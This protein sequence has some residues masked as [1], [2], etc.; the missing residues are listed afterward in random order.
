M[1]SRVLVAAIMIFALSSTAPILAQQSSTPEEDNLL[2]VTKCVWP[3][4]WS[5]IYILGKH[6]LPRTGTE[7]YRAL[8]S[9]LKTKAGVTIYGSN[10]DGIKYH[11]PKKGKY[12]LDILDVLN[13]YFFP[14]GGRVQVVSSGDVCVPVKKT[15]TARPDRSRL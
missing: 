9:E 7:E 11:V 2:R 13:N 8:A 4:G 12:P 10:G 5:Q 3:I 6:R 15:Q 14:A 1:I